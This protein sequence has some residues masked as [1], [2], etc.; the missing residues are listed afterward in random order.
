MVLALIALAI[1]VAFIA[2]GVIKSRPEDPPTMDESTRS[3]NASL[4]RRLLLMAAGSFGFGF[5][6]VPLYT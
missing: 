3:R 5:A 1:Y 6:L 2:S 4:T